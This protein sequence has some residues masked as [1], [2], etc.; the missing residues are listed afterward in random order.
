MIETE[1]FSDLYLPK[2]LD[3]SAEII[4]SIYFYHLFLNGITLLKLVSD[5]RFCSRNIRGRDEIRA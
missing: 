1:L 3:T 5:I 2:V 4:L